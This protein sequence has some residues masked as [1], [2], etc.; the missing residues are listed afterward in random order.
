MDPAGI[1]NDID[2]HLDAIFAIASRHGVG[3]DIHLHDGGA[4]GAFEL[5]QIAA[6]A[7]AL[8]LEG[9]L[10][11]SHAFCLG[12]L[13]DADFGR[14]AEALAEAGVAIM[15]TG[16]GPVPMPPVKR[17]KTY[18]VRVFCGSDNIRDAW[19]PFGNGDMLERAGIVCDRQNFRSDADLEEAFALTTDA[20]A[21]VLGRSEPA[22]GRRESGL[23]DPAR[24][25]HRRGGRVAANGPR[26]LQEWGLAGA[27]RAAA[28]GRTL[29]RRR[30]EG[31]TTATS[32]ISTTS[33]RR[34]ANSWR[35][36]TGA[37]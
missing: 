1:D 18:G 24:R 6:R 36:S 16:P 21:A 31:A 2:G 9:R 11:V 25:L 28:G 14:T 8:G 27:R 5:R 19:S 23:S 12:E 4:L 37:R 34:R 22:A 10:A 29:R 26:G 15:T 30:N 17:L 32:A 33:I 20:P 3:L 7:R 35:A 13:D